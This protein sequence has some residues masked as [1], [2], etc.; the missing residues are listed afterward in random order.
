MRH[1]PPLLSALLLTAAAA[2][3]S[4]DDAP[5]AGVPPADGLV[6]TWA[7]PLHRQEPRYPRRALER[8]QEGWVDISFV[9]E[10]DG[11]IADPVIE[12]SSGVPDLERAALDAVRR[13]EYAPATR[14]GEPVQQ[15]E[16]RTRLTFEIS[17]GGRPGAT[18]SYV[19][20]FREIS[21][22]HE[23]GQHEQ[24]M[25]QV[26]ELQRTQGMNRYETART[27]AMRAMLEQQ[28]GAPPEQLVASLRPA[29][30]DSW[31]ISNKE[32]H[33]S[34]LEALL[35]TE[36]RLR[37]YQRAIATAGRLREE[38]PEKAR[39]EEIEGVITELLALR[40][41]SSYLTVSGRIEP[42]A[43][44]DEHPSFWTHQPLRRQFGIEDV[45]GRISAVDL[46]CQWQRALITWNP[47]H[48]WR[49]PEDWGRC[50]IYVYGEPGTTFTLIEYP[51]ASG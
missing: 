1:W 30:A 25:E 22:L 8:G 21:R 44:D 7:Q 24:A 18:R 9:V 26:L 15:C 29:A 23:A 10:P 34:L 40:D 14:N 48:A 5:A 20:R 31:I 46:R 13:W 28:L 6:Q 27:W 12:G 45:E 50:D 38:V 39:R 11:S 36:I 42:P 16:V 35:A 47:E 37:H 51:Q 33:R 19:R 49:L 3:A 41:G 43:V 2:A 32:L 4:T 17:T